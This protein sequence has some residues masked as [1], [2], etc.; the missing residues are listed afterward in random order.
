LPEAGDDPR[1]PARECDTS[2]RRR[3]GSA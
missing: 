2:P 3:N 1:I